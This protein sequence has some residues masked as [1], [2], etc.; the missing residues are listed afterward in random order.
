VITYATLSRRLDRTAFPRVDDADVEATKVAALRVATGMILCWRCALMLRDS[1]FYFDPITWMGATIPV[2]VLAAAAQLGLSIGLCLGVRPA[3]CALV[4][5]ATHA[6]YSVWTGTYNLGPML[7][8]PMLGAFAALE[9][10]HKSLSARPIAPPAREVYRA[11]YLILFLCYAGLSFQALLYHVNDSYW[12]IGYTPAV[13]LTSSY[14]SEFY[15]IFRLLDG[16]APDFFRWSSLA[17]VLVQTVFQLAMVPLLASRTGTR[18]VMVWGWIFI[19]VS[20]ANLQ[21]SILPVVEVVLWAMIFVPGRAFAWIHRI[22]PKAAA[23][24]PRGRIQRAWQFVFTTGFGLM[25]ISYFGNAIS[26]YTTGHRLPARYDNTILFY[27]GLVA[28]NVF[29]REDL[30]MGDHW[31]V[32]ERMDEPFAGVVPLNGT[33]GERLAYH[34]SDLLYFGNSLP[35]RRAMIDQPDLLAYHEPGAGGHS[36]AF[37]VARYDY[38]RT[39]SAGPG[40][41]R[42]TLYRTQAANHELGTDPKRYQPEIVLTFTLEIGDASK[43]P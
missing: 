21:L 2:H 34:R 22:P 11:V 31:V 36:Y 28:P 20:L 43:S 40:L 30:T 12:I 42:C 23:T 1:L 32:I 7:L 8:V 10:G 17:I 38:R 13:L 26:G 37:L 19:L 33:D 6:A 39:G 16:A 25:L 4:L 35:W 15:T 14:L 24:F 9:T 18:F 3:F 27:S 29:N 5:M 41:Y